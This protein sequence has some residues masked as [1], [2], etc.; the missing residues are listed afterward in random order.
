M[1][2]IFFDVDDTLYSQQ[3]AFDGAFAELLQG[4]YDIDR[5]VLYKRFKHYSDESYHYY[6]DGEWTLDQVGVYRLM[7]SLEDYGLSCT[8]DLALAFQQSYVYHQNYI[9]LSDQMEQ[10]L[11]ELKDKVVLG[12]ITNGNGERQRG[13]VAALGLSRWI[14]EENIYISG[15]YPFAKP[16]L[17][18]FQLPQNTLGCQAEEILYVGDSYS[19]DME[20]AKAMGWHTIWMNRR[21]HLLPENDRIVDRMVTTEEDLCRA[22]ESLLY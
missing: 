11:K 1:K 10:L 17:R 2:A 3:Q 13:K 12:L 20:P 5:D 19:H 21:G 16:D 9:H 14:S 6:M 7:H 18:I 22:I 8:Q 15:D 4:K